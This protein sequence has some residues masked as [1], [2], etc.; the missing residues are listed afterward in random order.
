MDEILNLIIIILISVIVAVVFF[1]YFGRN[2]S[3]KKYFKFLI[4]W[5]FIFPVYQA[6][7]F[8][9]EIKGVV[10]LNLGVSLLYRQWIINIAIIIVSLLNLILFNK[11]KSN[12]KFNKF[13]TPLSVII[14]MAIIWPIVFFFKQYFAIVWFIVD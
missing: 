5:I 9:G 1:N 12:P 11:I 10:F 13:S 8:I 3:I 4:I 7:S 2:L 6:E 14:L